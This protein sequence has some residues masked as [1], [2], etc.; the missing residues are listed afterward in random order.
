[1]ECFG[2]MLFMHAILPF[3]NFYGERK[4]LKLIAMLLYLTASGYYSSHYYS[5]AL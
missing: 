2:F 5:F 4:L 3:P 1:M